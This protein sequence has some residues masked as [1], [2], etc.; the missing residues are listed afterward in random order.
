MLALAAGGARTRGFDAAPGRRVLRLRAAGAVGAPLDPSDCVIATDADQA[1]GARTVAFRSVDRHLMD[2]AAD[3]AAALLLP[4]PLDHLGDGDIV[5][6]DPVRGSIRVLYRRG[7]PSNSLLVTERCDH[8]CLMCSQPPK[9]VDDGHLFDEL[10]TAIPLIDPETVEIGITGGEPTIGGDRFLALIG[11]L[12]DRLPRT[13]VH[14]LSNGRRFL[15]P[16]FA[17]A[18]ATIGHHDLM[19]GIPIYADVAPV[20]DHIVQAKGAFDGTVR[21]ILNLKARG[22]RVEIR[23]VVVRQNWSR[24]RRT[25]EFIA[26]NLSFVDHV[27]LMA[28]EVTGFARANLDSVWVDPFDY[29]HELAEAAL[30]LEAAGVRVSLYNHQLCTVEPAVRHLARRSISDWKN[31]YL[32]V[33]E[34]CSAKRGCAGFFAT[35]RTRHSAHIAPL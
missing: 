27:A 22:A 16:A 7:S 24:L 33:C 23:V 3:A 18:Y 34:D 10:D 28:L 17:A 2:R 31:E 5:A 11:S 6:L 20:H 35:G 21:G 25:A 32:A 29:R 30:W 13:A 9:D 8:Y 14:V 12:R 26:R 19:T 4:S 15:D 1:R